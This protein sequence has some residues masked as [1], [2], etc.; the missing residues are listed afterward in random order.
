MFVQAH[1]PVKV[2]KCPSIKLGVDECLLGN[3]GFGE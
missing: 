3:G 2:S 1:E